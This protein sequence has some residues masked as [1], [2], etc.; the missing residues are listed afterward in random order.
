MP[1]H[2]CKGDANNKVAFIL[3][4]PGKLEGEAECPAAGD[5]GDN[6][7][8][9]LTLLNQTDPIHFQS[10]DRY[11][12]LITNASTKVMHAKNGD[13]R[14]EDGDLNIK[15]TKNVNRVRAEV[16]RCTI[17]IL[18]GR[19]AGLLAPYLSEKI[20]IRTSHLGN[21]GLRNKFRNLAPSLQGIA[22]GEERDAARNKL[23]ADEISE[24]L[25]T[26]LAGTARGARKVTQFD[27]FNLNKVPR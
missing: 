26:L 12:Y 25:R 20:L 11:Q 18:C 7:D 13:K 15:K 5:T 9:I 6:M 4:A 17:I 27:A 2:L 10:V 19:K 3:S 14:T 22:T 23:C 21:K 8:A 24:Q 1:A 16:E